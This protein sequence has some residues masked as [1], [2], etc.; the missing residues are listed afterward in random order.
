MERVL[1]VRHAESAASLAGVV[2][3]VPGAGVGLSEEGQRQAQAL[4]D[5]LAPVEVD[6]C[7][8]TQFPRTVETADLALAGRGVRR[9][10]VPELNDPDYGDFEGGS[11]DV[12]R[13][14]AAANTASVRPPGGSESRAEIVARYA[15][16]YRR[17]LSRPEPA[18]AGFLHS[19]PIAYLLSAAE[20][21]HPRAK[22][23]LIEY[24][25]VLEIDAEGMDRAVSRLEAWAKAPTW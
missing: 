8:V 15:R 14:W 20:G 3:G 13:E 16:G 6:L 21:H 25:T 17:L 19:L 7:V 1:L 11:L 12:F 4:A 2:N 18:V 5:V 23:R 9:L 22:E 24:S 10:V